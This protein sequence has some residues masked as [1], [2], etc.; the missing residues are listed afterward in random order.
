MKTRNILIATVMAI[1]SAVCVQAA[2]PDVTDYVH[3]PTLTDL[4]ARAPRTV[5]PLLDRNTRL[6]MVDYY[7]SGLS[8]PSRNLIGG[9]SRITVADSVSLD[10]AM[11][12]SSSYHMT[13]LP[14]RG[15]T[16]IALVRTV[17][18]PTPDS[19]LQLY[20][21]TWQPATGVQDFTL[22]GLDE[23]LKS[24]IKGTDPDV[25]NLIPFVTTTITIDNNLLTL[26]PSLDGRYTRDDS[27]KV[28]DV[29]R[30]QIQYSWDGNKLRFKKL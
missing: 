5:F 18:L 16:I 29:M 20:T 25:V 7:N 6:D 26:K 28:A 17:N 27:T 13:L 22:P 12:G 4:F 23:W 19:D 1:V 21:T 9:E 24:G 10:I 8:T 30:Q 2:T 14:A 3:I 15:D 11:S